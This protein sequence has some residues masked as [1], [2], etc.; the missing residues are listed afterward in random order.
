MKLYLAPS[1][2]QMGARTW[3]VTAIFEHT[4]GDIKEVKADITCETAQQAKLALRRSIV[5]P[6]QGWRLTSL[7]ARIRP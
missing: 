3:R 1:G 7:S 5:S 4:T 6:P 2:F